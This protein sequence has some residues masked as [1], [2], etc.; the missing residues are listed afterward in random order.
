MII[1]INLIQNP[2]ALFPKPKKDKVR[3]KGRSFF[4]NFLEKRGV[5]FFVIFQKVQV[6]PQLRISGA[7]RLKF[8][9]AA[10]NYSYQ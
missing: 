6:R 5:S 2:N 9:I 7:K 10:H 4:L 1:F 3:E 8:E